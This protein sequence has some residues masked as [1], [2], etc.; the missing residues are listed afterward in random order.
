MIYT[1]TIN[2]ACDRS[3]VINDFAAGK[4]NRI[5]T[6]HD[7]PGGKGI[8]V[9][10]IIRELGGESVAMGIIGGKTGEFIKTNLEHMGISTDFVVSEN[11]TRTNI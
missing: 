11:E 5:L 2:P 3:I 6:T 7:D 10:K 4:V 1:V 9:S 8:N